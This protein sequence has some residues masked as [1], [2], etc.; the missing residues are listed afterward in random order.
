MG[1][2]NALANPSGSTLVNP[3]PSGST[4][5]QTGTGTALRR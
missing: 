1:N 2:P 3:S 5:D 4:L